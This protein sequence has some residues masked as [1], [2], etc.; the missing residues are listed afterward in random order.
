[1]VPHVLGA[2]SMPWPRLSNSGTL[3]VYADESREELLDAVFRSALRAAFS[4]KSRRTRGRCG[5]S[6][7]PARDRRTVG[8][9][10]DALRR[11][12]AQRTLHRLLVREAAAYDRTTAVPAPVRVQDVAVHTADFRAE[13]RDRARALGRAHPARLLAGRHRERS[14]CLQPRARRALA[15]RAEGRLHHSA[16]HVLLSPLRRHPPPHLGHGPRPR[17]CAGEAQR[18]AARHLRHPALR[19]AGLVGAARAERARDEPAQPTRHA[20]SARGRPKRACITGGCSA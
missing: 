16:R 20:F 3:V 8:S 14:G 15:W 19:G 17:A 13:P 2:A 9:R 5:S 6:P 18:G 10:A 7:A 11:L 4:R 1:M 12:G